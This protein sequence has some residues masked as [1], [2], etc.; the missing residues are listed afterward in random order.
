MF[1]LYSTYMRK[2][3]HLQLKAHSHHTR[4]HNATRDN[5][6]R[7]TACRA[8]NPCAVPCGTRVDIQAGDVWRRHDQSRPTSGKR[9][10]QLRQ[11]TTTRGSAMAERPAR[12]SVSVEMLSYSQQYRTVVRITQTNRVSAWRAVSATTLCPSWSQAKIQIFIKTP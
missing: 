6:P 2:R 3:W 7:R 11:D 1:Y 5:T 12:R 10:H 9:S 4:Y 8:A